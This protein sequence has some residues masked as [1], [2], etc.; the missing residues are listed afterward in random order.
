MPLPAAVPF[1][2]ALVPL[3]MLADCVVCGAK[4]DLEVDIADTIMVVDPIDGVELP[5]VIVMRVVAS[6]AKAA[7]ARDSDAADAADAADLTEAMEAAV[8]DA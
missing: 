1:P 7:D 2:L 6:D 3:A 4:L 8:C 5:P